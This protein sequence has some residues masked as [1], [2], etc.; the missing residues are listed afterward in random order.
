M[1]QIISSKQVFQILYRNARLDAKV[2]WFPDHVDPA[3]VDPARFQPGGDFYNSPELVAWRE[4][5]KAD[6]A[7]AR[8][9]PAYWDMLFAG[10]TC[11]Q[12]RDAKPTTLE[13]KLHDLKSARTF[14]RLFGMEA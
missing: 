1:K 9:H 14:T 4:R 6:L 13:E 5:C 2:Q 3:N 10:M 8:K 7:I 11:R 12:L